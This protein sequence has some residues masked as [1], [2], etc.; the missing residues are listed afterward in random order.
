[1]RHIWSSIENRPFGSTDMKALGIGL[2]QRRKQQIAEGTTKVT[3]MKRQGIVYRQIMGNCGLACFLVYLDVFF[4]FAI[5]FVSPGI[6]F[7]AFLRFRI[8]PSYLVFNI[9]R[10]FQQWYTFHLP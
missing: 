8:I 6:S 1:M 2:K 5:W 9:L 10:V 3:L 4:S 7:S